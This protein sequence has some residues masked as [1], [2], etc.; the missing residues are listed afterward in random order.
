MGNNPSQQRGPQIPVTRVSSIDIRKFCQ[1]LSQK[2]KRNVRLPTQAEWEYAARV[3]ASNPPFNQKSAKQINAGPDR[4]TFLPVK[5][6]QPN[7]WG[8]YDM[9]CVCSWEIIRDRR[10]FSRKD[11]VDPYY[12]IKES[13]I[14]HNAMGRTVCS[15]T[16]TREGVGNGSGKGYVL[17]RFRVAV[18]AKPEEIAE[19]KKTAK[20]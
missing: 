4:K 8:L 15:Y 20:K 12:L 9:I 13:K 16:T 11:A 10:Q 17:T 1:V 6:K 5:S 19:M 7:A 2:N 14:S 18:E 3:G